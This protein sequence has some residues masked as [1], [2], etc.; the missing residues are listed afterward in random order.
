M[1]YKIIYRV[2]DAVNS[3]HMALDGSNNPRPD[4]MTKQDVIKT[5]A[6]SVKDS[7]NGLDYDMFIVGDR[8]SNET[9]EFVNDVFQP[10]Y[11]KNYEEKLGDGNS[12]IEC[13][14]IAMEQ[15]DED[16]LYFLEDDYL[17]NPE[18]FI[19]KMDGF[20]ELSKTFND[21]PWFIHPT[22][23]PD[24]YRNLTKSYVL[25]T[26]SGYWREVSSTTHTFL[27]LKKNYK[28]FVNFF[29]KCHEQDGNDGALSSIF[30]NHA[31]CFCPLPGIAT[32]VHKGT[33]SNYVNWDNLI[34]LYNY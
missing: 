33:Y 13:S 21:I 18:S 1:K 10:K 19:S 32:H 16:L 22:D 31:I 29:R 20:L 25:Q 14:K 28:K 8:V 9:W 34:K 26:K 24:Q 3:L 11:S 6:R 7:I 4:G 2:C 27:S 15:E 5:C 17:H 12:L 23:Y 30:G